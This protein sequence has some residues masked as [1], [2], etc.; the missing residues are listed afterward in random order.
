MIIKMAKS[1]QSEQSDTKKS[2]EQL[3]VHY[4]RLIREKPPKVPKN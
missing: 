4:V 2:F 3:I 1:E